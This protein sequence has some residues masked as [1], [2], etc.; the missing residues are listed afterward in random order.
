M[1]PL[2]PGQ[3][4]P[5]GWERVPG[6][7]GY[8]REKRASSAR[9]PLV[10]AVIARLDIAKGDTGE[11]GPQGVRGPKGEQGPQGERGHRGEQGPMGGPKG[12]RGE[13]GEQG[14]KGEQ[15]ADGRDGKNGVDGKAGARGLKGE[16]GANG[17]DGTDGVGIA[18]IKA[19]GSDMLVML[20]DGRT[21]RLMVGGGSVTPFGG[22]GGG[23]GGGGPGTQ[24]VY[25]Q[26]NQPTFDAGQVALWVQ[27]GMAPNGTGFTLWFEDGQV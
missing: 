20:S 26:S 19:N 9:D 8:I 11:Q 7:P 23:G 12:E 14:L 24:E 16:P 2:A 18:D 21:Q 4:P 1:K 22:G 17:R 13:R 10:D 25:V 3:L 6:V 5:A 15:G 27:T